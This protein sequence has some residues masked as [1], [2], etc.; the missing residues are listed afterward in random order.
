MCLP[1]TRQLEPC[2]AVIMVDVGGDCAPHGARDDGDGWPHAAPE[3]PLG[4]ERE[5]ATHSGPL[6]LAGLGLITLRHLDL[7]GNQFADIP[8]WLGTRRPPDQAL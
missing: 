7:A 3:A 1:L 5:A 4:V 6:S 2:L 8:R